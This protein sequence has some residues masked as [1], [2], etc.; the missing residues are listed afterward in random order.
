VWTLSVR[1]IVTVG[2][3]IHRATT[4]VLCSSE[5][6]FTLVWKSCQ[7]I[8]HVPVIPKPLRMRYVFI[9][10]CRYVID[11]TGLLQ[12]KIFGKLIDLCIEICLSFLTISFVQFIFFHKVLFLLC[13]FERAV[14]LRN[15]LNDRCEDLTSWGI[16]S[17]PVMYYYFLG[18]SYTHTLT[19]IYTYTHTEG[20]YTFMQ[21]LHVHAYMH[22]HNVHTATSCQ[23]YATDRGNRGYEHVC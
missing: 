15:T 1:H 16:T 9:A 12:Y 8:L 2:K 18:T 22:T 11:S 23:Y 14:L 19:C 5:W 3:H 6:Q 7:R 13:R 20:Q 4:P 17:E 10:N 21:K